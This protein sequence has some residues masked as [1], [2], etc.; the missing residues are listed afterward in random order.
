MKPAGPSSPAVL[1]HDL[2][3]EFKT[4]AARR[5]VFDY[6]R[7]PW[8]TPP[9]GIRSALEGVDFV[10]PRGEWLAVIGPNGAGK[11][12]LLR[13]LAGLLRPT[14]GRVEVHGERVLVTALGV[15]MLDE[16]SV[17][18]NVF[19]YGAIYGLDRARLKHLL[20][21]VMEW[22]EL[23]G[24]DDERLRTLSA[25]MRGRLAFSILRYID[26]PIVLLD[27]ALSA[28][29]LAFREKCREFFEVQNGRGRTFVIV[30]H[31]LAFAR[32]FCPRAVW[33]DKGRQKDAGECGRI[34]DAYT[35]SQLPAAV[36]RV[37]PAS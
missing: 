33:L 26:A 16:L 10:V 29:D 15:G 3:K 23:T 27:E 34:A 2:A 31:D 25:G 14:R 20:P 37:R 13:I 11:T 1:V 36:G 19:L 32:R 8:R 7:R 22:A 35:R 28:G 17:S 9:T 30:T 12:T 4:S 21:D 6:L 5:S 24:L 18:D